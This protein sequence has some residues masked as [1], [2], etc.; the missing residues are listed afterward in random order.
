M[1]YLLET[2]FTG[3]YNMLEAIYY[4]RQLETEQL[5]HFSVIPNL[6]LPLT[7]KIPILNCLWATFLLSRTLCD[8]NGTCKLQDLNAVSDRLK[9]CS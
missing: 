6:L 8:I 3:P 9:S 7:T 5:R 4:Y 1:I 2:Y